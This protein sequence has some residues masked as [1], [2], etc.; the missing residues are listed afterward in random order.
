MRV[1]Q[2]ECLVCRK[3]RGE[4]EVPGGELAGDE[5]ATV[6]HVPRLDGEAETYLGWFVVEPRRHTPARGTAT[7]EEAASIGVLVARAARA[8]G[9]E[10][11][12]HVCSFV[13]GHGVPH[14][15]VHVVGRGPG[16]PRE[17][18]GVRLPEWPDAR[19]GG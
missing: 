2:A 19:Q 1:A 14:L 7:D 8:L 9:A 18:W 6:A 12:E 16:T 11:A 5:V 13:L 17:W 10:G 15:H 4:I 3:H